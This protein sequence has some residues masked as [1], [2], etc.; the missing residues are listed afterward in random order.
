MVFCFQ[1]EKD[2]LYKEAIMIYTVTFNPSLDYIIQVKDFKTGQINK[3]TYEKILPGGKG[4]NVAI[5]LSN[6][7]HSSTALGFM[8]G[9]TGKEIEHRLK[10]FGCS[11]SFIQVKEGLSRINV[12]MKSNEETEIN[13][14]GPNIQKENIEELFTQLEAMK[15]EDILVISGSIPGTLPDTMYEQILQRVQHI[16]CKVVV[17]ATNT[18]LM[19]V[20]PYHPFLIKP[21]NIELGE[22]F[23][24]E[25]STQEEVLPYAHKLQELGAR[26]ILVSM[27]GKGAV[28]LDENGKEH[29]SLAPK[30]TVINSVGAGDSMV[31]GFISGCI[32]SDYDYSHAF[33]KGV[34][35]GSASAFSEN[36][37]TK[38]EVLALM[39]TM[40]G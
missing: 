36:L 3:T 18:L 35:S 4:I 1:K 5:V 27:A 8:A 32:E 17:D 19:K 7:G 9:F 12:K 38:E 16:G 28:L 15:K 34:C 30:G 20:L 6:L 10:E 33:I 25:L 40:K 23:G 13:G 31:A 24:V 26:N 11:S 21:N 2:P 39:E 29:R 37:C 22:I 14:Q